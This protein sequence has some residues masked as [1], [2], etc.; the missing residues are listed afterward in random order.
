MKWLEG[1]RISQHSG[2]QPR[3]K[4]KVPC[5]LME[6]TVNATS[7]WHRRS[8]GAGRM[9]ESHH[10]LLGGSVP[11]LRAPLPQG[12]A[13]TG[14]YHPSVSHCLEFQVEDPL[15]TRLSRGASY[16]GTVV[17]GQK[18][19]I[20]FSSC[21]SESC[22]ILVSRVGEVSHNLISFFH[23]GAHRDLKST[24]TTI[25]VIKFCS[26]TARKRRGGALVTALFSHQN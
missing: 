5:D 24:T 22:H 13:Q 14:A 19:T 4:V 20:A 16:R 21:T 11:A 12:V 17:I 1:E 6:D 2:S 23:Q 15:L 10:S 8:T 26:I 3:N 25:T 18:E 7:S 9:N